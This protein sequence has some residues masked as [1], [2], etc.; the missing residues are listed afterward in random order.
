VPFDEIAPIVDRSPEATRQLASRARRRVQGERSIPDAD[1]D[2]QRVVV[3]AFMAA[4]REGDFEALV[5]LL[6]PD[7]VVRADYGGGRTS[8]V[9]GAEA[10]ASQAQ[11]F[12]RLDLVVRPAL[13]NGAVGAVS[14]LHGRPFSVGAMTIRNGKIVELDFLVDPERLAKLDLTI[15]AD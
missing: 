12:A 10:V 13:V 7:V 11:M 6:D 15:L 9:R 14:M 1:L 4:S 5:A 8:E 3:D 2:Q